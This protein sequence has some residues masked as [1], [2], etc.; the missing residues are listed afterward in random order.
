MNPRKR[1]RDSSSD[2]SLSVAQDEPTGAEAREQANISQ[3]NEMPMNSRKPVK[4]ADGRVPRP[5]QGLEGLRSLNSLSSSQDS[6]YN[7]AQGG[8]S[9]GSPHAKQGPKAPRAFNGAK[10]P[11][12]SRHFD[13][14]DND[15]HSPALASVTAP[16]RDKQH[17]FSLQQS[18]SQKQTQTQTTRSTQT[19]DQRKTHTERQ[20]SYAVTVTVTATSQKESRQPSSFPTSRL[21]PPSPSPVPSPAA[22]KLTSKA[23]STSY[24][25]PLPLFQA[26][27]SKLKSAK[28]APLTEQNLLS[29]LRSLDSSPSISNHP[30]F[31]FGEALAEPPPTFSRRPASGPAPAPAP[32]ATTRASHNSTFTTGMRKSKSPKKHD[33][34]RDKEKRKSKHDP[35][36]HP[37][38][39]PPDQLR[40]LFTAQMARQEAEANRS[41]MSM[42]R[43]TPDA[44]EQN[45]V[46]GSSPPVTP[47]KEAPG[48]FPE[49]PS[50]HS[51]NGT[52]NASDERSPTPPPHRVTPQKVDPEACKASGNKFFKARDYERAIA[53]YT[54]GMAHAKSPFCWMVH[55]SLF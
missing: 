54:K 15:H 6:A 36:T 43:D 35:N 11:R 32:E 27:E 34:D 51:T 23:R 29:H 47:S 18:Q 37:L 8:S 45:F 49:H 12:N 20:T 14:K 38:N 25:S 13:G 33:K 7:D 4:G 17:K 41:S 55:F 22:G 16:A 1:C 28:A 10:N 52:S 42:D 50:D 24:T 44:S 46:N 39:L 48:A 2:H 5:G 31:G 19:Q 21:P 40:Q 3:T 30:N 26:D 9:G 53:E